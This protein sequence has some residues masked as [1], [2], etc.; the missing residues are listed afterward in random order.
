MV[1]DRAPLAVL[2]LILDTQAEN[3]R[4]VVEALPPR[5]TRG[6]VPDIRGQPRKGE[7][8]VPY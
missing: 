7:A 8:D 4:A 1:N 2:P 6:S 5:Y 3:E